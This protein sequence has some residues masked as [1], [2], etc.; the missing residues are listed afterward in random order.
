MSCSAWT[1]YTGID[2]SCTSDESTNNYCNRNAIKTTLDSE[3]CTIVAG[4]TMT[5]FNAVARCCQSTLSQFRP[6]KCKSQWGPRS[7]NSTVSC[8]SNYFMAQCAF[9][10][11]EAAFDVRG[12]WINDENECVTYSEVP[13]YAVANCCRFPSTNPPSATPTSNT[14]NPTV[15]PTTY[16]PSN[17]PT[18]TPSSTPSI[19]PS[20]TPSTSPTNTPTTFPTLADTPTRTPT[21]T[22]SK[23]PNEESTSPTDSPTT[24]PTNNPI[25][26]T[27]KSDDGSSNSNDLNINPDP[28]QFKQILP[29]I[30]I[31]V[32]SFIT[33]GF[34][35]ILCCCICFPKKNKSKL[36]METN[37]MILNNNNISH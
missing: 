1:Y 25:Q 9:Y 5:E 32:G 11:N 17:I 35:G 13:V 23:S 4:H 2:G 8:P 37:E 18:I 20:N 21:I 34:F 12:F 14:P 15:S 10:D 26:N 19:S 30:L 36:E 27:D 3:Y 33:G 31:V 24:S 29:W 7:I 16:P 22:P 6:L 28:S